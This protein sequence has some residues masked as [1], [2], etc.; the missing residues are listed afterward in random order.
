MPGRY[1]KPE[2]SSGF[3]DTI[4]TYVYR[5]PV[6]PPPAATPGGADAAPQGAPAPTTQP[7]PMPSPATQPPPKSGDP[8]GRS[9]P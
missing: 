7:P 5:R 9:A 3:L 2:M 6:P 8:G 1:A 4:D